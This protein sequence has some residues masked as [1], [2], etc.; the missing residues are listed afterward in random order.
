MKDTSITF[1]FTVVF[2]RIFWDCMNLI[3]FISSSSKLFDFHDIMNHTFT[4]T[5]RCLTP[6]KQ[7][8]YT[9]THTS[10]LRMMRILELAKLPIF[11]S[12]RVVLISKVQM[13]RKFICTSGGG[14]GIYFRNQGAGGRG[15][16]REER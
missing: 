12:H 15:D 16:I 9:T 10:V 2:P 11:F 4:F 8:L 3:I 5:H 6:H 14:G 7:I 13:C 1:I